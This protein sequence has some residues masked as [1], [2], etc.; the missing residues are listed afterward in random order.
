MF[1]FITIL[2]WPITW[3]SL[4]NKFKFFKVQNKLN[5][6]HFPGWNW[7]MPQIMWWP[8]LPLQQ[9]SS[10]VICSLCSYLHI[11]RRQH[12]SSFTGLYILNILYCITLCAICILQYSCLL[13]LEGW[14]LIWLNL[15]SSHSHAYCTYLHL[16]SKTFGFF[17]LDPEK[18]TYWFFV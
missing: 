13:V 7:R 12:C 16:W 1:C 14:D 5:S 8:W 17:I 18:I 4:H 11:W 9:W 6:L 3:Y 15:M 10:W 2:S